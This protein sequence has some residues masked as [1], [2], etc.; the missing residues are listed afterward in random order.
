MIDVINIFM[1]LRLK[2]GA[3]ILTQMGAVW[4]TICLI[5]CGA[6]ISGL[7]AWITREPLLGLWIPA[8]MII[9][10]H[11]AR[12]DLRFL[13]VHTSTPLTVLYAEYAALALPFAI[14]YCLAGHYLAA[15]AIYAIVAVAPYS[16]M[17]FLRPAK[18]TGALARLIPSAAF[19]WKTGLRANA[20]LIF[21]LYCAA[22]A[23]SP[24][25]ATAPIFAIVTALVVSG[26]YMQAE[27][28]EML[29]AFGV[30]AREILHRKLMLYGKLYA[31]VLSPPTLLFLWL[32]TAYWPV[33]AIG[34]ALG[35][36][37][38]A[39]AIIAKYAYYRPGRALERNKLLVAL[40]CACCFIPP[41]VV[42]PFVVIALTYPKALKNIERYI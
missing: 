28:K 15:L 16:R 13:R 38:L 4:A 30:S 25:A 12:S 2:Q 8:G 34:F 29:Q 3:R 21:A 32:H 39:Y 18:R 1:V 5:L 19:E 42:A 9:A 11:N 17:E 35:S 24:F 14:A 6:V 23:L 40:V 26:F 37:A 22:L 33:L 41:L 36:T 27:S 10:V 31:A 20:P 7:L